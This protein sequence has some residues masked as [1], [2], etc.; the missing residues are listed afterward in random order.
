MTNP[1]WK[2]VTP[3]ECLKWQID[4]PMMEI[5]ADKHDRQWSQ[6]WNR[7]KGSFEAMSSLGE[8]FPD[9]CPGDPSATY[10]IPEV[11]E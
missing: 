1:N 9:D 7:A 5:R 8:F 2:Q 6:R 4:N 3:A 10:F 11:T